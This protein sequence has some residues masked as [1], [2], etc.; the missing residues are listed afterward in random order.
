MHYTTER[1]ITIV[2]E[3][4]PG[5]LGVIGRLLAAEGVN[6]EALSVIDNIEQGVVRLVTSDADRCRRVLAGAGLY[7]VEAD[8]LVVGTADRPGKLA[9][10]C[11]ALAAARINVDYAYTSAAG[12]GGDADGRSRLIFKVSNLKAAQEIFAALGE[13]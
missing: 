8:V 9:E 4:Q 7:L 13:E 12:H 1:Q 5:R 10:I 11:D 2:L 3:N 6:I